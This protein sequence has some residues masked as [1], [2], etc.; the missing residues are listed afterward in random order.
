MNPHF[1][2]NCINGIDAMIQSNDKYRATMYLNKFARLIRNVLD[3]SKKNKIPIS[4]DLETLQLYIDLELF[5]HHDKFTA[6]IE[7]DEELLQNDYAVPPLIIQPF[8]ENAILH[9]LRHKKDHPGKLK[10]TVTK[11]NEHIS[12]SIEDNGVGR[13]EK[14]GEGQMEGKGYGMQMSNDRIRL[15]NNEEIASVQITDLVSKGQPQGT[16]VEV[17]LKIQ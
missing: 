15:F 9:G 6:S 8:V 1:I 4:K 5:R 13:K 10:V 12:F 11:K 7:V 3:N 17:Q 2:F 16:R 14:N